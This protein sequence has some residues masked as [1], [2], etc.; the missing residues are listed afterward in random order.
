MEKWSTSKPSIMTF[1]NTIYEAKMP[2]FCRRKDQITEKWELECHDF[3]R[4]TL[5]AK[6]TMEQHVQNFKE[7][8]F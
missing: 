8:L 1:E 4:V 7:K 5:E 2:R 3:T 6:I